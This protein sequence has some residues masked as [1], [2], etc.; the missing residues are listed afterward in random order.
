MFIFPYVELAS[1][2]DEIKLEYDFKEPEIDENAPQDTPPPSRFT[3]TTA[4]YYDFDLDG[5][6]DRSVCGDLH[7][8]SGHPS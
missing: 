1:E 3:Q 6:Y 8:L 2:L 5:Q 7:G 4:N